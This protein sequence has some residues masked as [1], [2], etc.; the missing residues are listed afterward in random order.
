MALTLSIAKASPG[1]IVAGVPVNFTVTV[2]NTGSAAVS[3]SS[4]QVSESTES[5][6]TIAQ[7][8]YLTPN[9]PVGV[10]NPVLGAGASASYN[11]QAVFNSPYSAGSSPNAAGGASPG[12]A[13][14]D[15]FFTLLAQGQLSDGSVGS[16]PLVVPVLSTIAPFPLAQGGAFQFGQGFNFIN[17]IM[18]GAI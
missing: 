6:A 11:F 5:D 10:G 9:V 17:L 13:V 18:L 3:L 1:S 16:F 12:P 7:P 4:L 15:P 8:N 2:T 14:A